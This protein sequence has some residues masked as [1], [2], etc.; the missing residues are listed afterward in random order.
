[1]TSAAESVGD[2]GPSERVSGEKLST[3]RRG[4][5]IGGTYRLLDRIGSGGMGDVYSAEHTRLGR[6]FAVKLLRAD[7][8]ARAIELF[9][10]EAR[11]IARIQNE[12]VVG[13][14][15]CG[16]TNDGAPYLVMERLIGEDLRCLLAHCAPLPI[17]RAVSLICDAC[18]GV[19]AV[20][21]AGL[22]HRDL[23]PGNLFVTRRS[24]G[25]DW[26]KV[27]DFGVA[28]M[29]ASVS[30]AEGVLVGT[31]RYM[32]P[33]QLQDGASAGPRVDIY[34]L[35]AILY[36]SLSGAPP[37][38]GVSTQELMF[39]I[40]NEEPARIDGRRREVPR[41][42]ADAIQ[43]ALAKRP[44]QRF[45]SVQEFA[46]AI[47]PFAQASVHIDSTTDSETL[48]F[49]PGTDRSTA[50]LKRRMQTAVTSLVLTLILVAWAVGKHQANRE[51][52]SVAVT[53]AQVAPLSPPTAQVLSIV[54]A[55]P[56][57]AESPVRAEAVSSSAKALEPARPSKRTVS[58]QA[59]AP[60][61][62]NA[63]FDIDN[64]YAH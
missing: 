52:R 25:E 58:S 11:A 1:M 32:A 21:R 26:C 28:K 35:G 18:E 9:R 42:L 22:V 6:Q 46:R 43:C 10:R 4:E 53:S 2:D 47:S 27:L 37:H 62:P 13:V 14:V 34:A 8:E 17:P 3:T 30:T 29:E 56:L 48:S 20:H 45:A 38:S 50:N 16:E 54:Q 24:T 41:R 49:E 57:T 36:E 19:A 51:Q 61:F 63:R 44:S 33:E 40:M 5:L 59:R 64:P 55:V 7:A 31:V 12:Y 60:K 15:D 39:K 23:K